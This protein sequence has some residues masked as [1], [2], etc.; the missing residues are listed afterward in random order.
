MKN[1]Q[2]KVAEHTLKLLSSNE[3][4]TISFEKICLKLKLNKKKMSKH[5]KDK[6]DLLKNINQY[7]D[8]KILIAIKSLDTST[9]RDMIFEIMMLRFDLLNCYR[10]SIL[11]IFEIFK[12][13]PKIFIIL[14]PVFINSII[15]IAKA[16]N[17]ETKGILG[18][19]KIKGMLVIYFSTFLTWVKDE[20]PALNKTMTAL[21]NYLERAENFLKLVKS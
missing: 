7:F 17:I 9:S 6:N 20:K 1:F 18:S 4:S 11:K 5:F 16:S 8:D 21:D 3:W 10:K 14:L 13:Q 19:I 12:S 2:E 15:L